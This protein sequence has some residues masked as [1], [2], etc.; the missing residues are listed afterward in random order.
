MRTMILALVAI[1][2]VAAAPAFAGGR[3]GQVEIGGYIGYIWPDDYGIFHPDNHTMFGA[4]L[5]YWFTP[6][7]TLELT[8]QKWKEE[9]DFDIV[10]LENQDFDNKSGRLNL[11]YNFGHSHS[12]V[13]PFL[14]AGAD[15]DKT[16]VN[17]FGESCDWGW[18]AGGGL[19]FF[20]SPHVNL[21]AEGRYTRTKVGDEV[22]ESQGNAEASLGLGFLLGGH[23]H[24][25]VSEAPPPPP[26]NQPPTV[27]C[28]VDR[29]QVLPGETVNVH[30]SAADPENGPL[31]YDWTTTAGRLSGT[32]AT[33][34]LSFDG[35]TPPTSATITVKV[36][37]DHGNPASSDCT[38]ALAAPAPPPAAVSCSA[39]GFPRNLSR[40]TNVDKACLDDVA[41]KL[42][43]DP[44]AHVVIIGHSDSHET[45]TGI[46][47]KRANAMRDYLVKERSIDGTRVTTRTAP[48]DEGAA[49]AVAQAA[50][51]KVEVWFVPEGAADPQ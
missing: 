22:D 46:G 23:E 6:Q 35:V 47:M 34:A 42:G 49:D 2:L 41:Q 50:N 37:D 4:R 5:G 25:E 20:L 10:G 24:H 16:K 32:G 45:A 7:W 19:R 21:R 11:L 39:G 33:V 18:N 51:R 9:T 3:G 31:T 29:S 44:R 48:P 26:P 43:T 40:I 30:A 36:T 17:T 15:Y 1:L 13:R 8:G 14:T 27:T 12:K 38:V 28:A